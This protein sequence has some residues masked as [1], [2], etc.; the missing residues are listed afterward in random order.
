MTDSDFERIYNNF[1]GIFCLVACI[2]VVFTGNITLAAAS[3]DDDNWGECKRN[4]PCYVE[5]SYNWNGSLIVNGIAIGLLFVPPVNNRIIAIRSN[6]TRHAG[7]SRKDK[8]LVK[9]AESAAK[10]M[11]IERELER[12]VGV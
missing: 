5:H 8:K 12:R 10:R 2:L 7:L 4:D 6:R 9:K 11:E 3:A 1:I